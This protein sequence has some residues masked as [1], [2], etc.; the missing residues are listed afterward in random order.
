MSTFAIKLIATLA[1]CVLIAPYDYISAKSYKHTPV[2]TIK[3]MNTA[4]NY[5]YTS[6]LTG[7][8]S[9]LSDD[10]VYYEAGNKD[11]LPYTGTYH[12]KQGLVDSFT[13]F[14]TLFNYTLLSPICKSCS[15]NANGT[16]GSFVNHYSLTN[17]ATNATNPSVYSSTIC[18]LGPDGLLTFI[19]DIADSLAEFNVLNS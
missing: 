14:G 18:Y 9:L 5:I 8:V 11:Q 10:V 2:T 1:L 4:Y 6:N 19:N 12:G 17:W 13:T 3:L 16:I 15:S 7:L